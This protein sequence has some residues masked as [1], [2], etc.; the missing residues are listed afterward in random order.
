[1][2]LIYQ[3]LTQILIGCI[4]DVHNKLGT[5][6]D[7]EAYHQGL[8][9]RF[10]QENIPFVSKERK[11]LLHRNMQI[12]FFELDILAYNKII[13]SL[14]N[15]QSDFLQPHKVQIISELKL[16]QKNLGLLVNFGLPR[17][18]YKRVPF[19][20]KK[21]NIFEDYD[22]IKKQISES[23]RQILKVIREAL[24]FIFKCHGLGYGKSI[25]KKIVAAEFNFQRLNFKTDVPIPVKYDQEIIRHCE[26][27][28]L[29]V[30]DR[31][32]LGITALRKELNYEIVTIQTYL[33][34]LGLSIGLVVNF[35]RTHLELIGVR[36]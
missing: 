4:Y 24:L 23:D 1:M 27:R 33:K 28:Y 2:A 6:Y 25:Y 16:W 36:A 20:E 8:L 29:L 17:V 9:R 18:N 5:G 13:L 26:M 12:R 14:K 19:S 3:D 30:E 7:E 35:G 32:I 22:Y 21:K 11:W 31:I 15:I 10:K 34:A